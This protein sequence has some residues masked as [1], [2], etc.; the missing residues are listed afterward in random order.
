M[1]RNGTSGVC[2][3]RTGHYR[4]GKYDFGRTIYTRLTATGV[5]AVRRPYLPRPEEEG[6]DEDDEVAGADCDAR[7]SAGAECD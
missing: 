2:P 6:D 4:G 3:A 1:P 7:D 5:R